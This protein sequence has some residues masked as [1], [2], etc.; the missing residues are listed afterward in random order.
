[1]GTGIRKGITVPHLNGYCEKK[2]GGKRIW[3]KNR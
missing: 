1:M 2:T 3:R